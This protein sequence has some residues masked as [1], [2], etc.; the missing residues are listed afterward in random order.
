M[1]KIYLKVEKIQIIRNLDALFQVCYSKEQIFLR[2]GSEQ[3]DVR[4]TFHK[5]LINIL[6]SSTH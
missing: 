6:N 4:V 1:G 3:N 5:H 2:T